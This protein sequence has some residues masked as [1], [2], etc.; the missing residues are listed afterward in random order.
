M[1]VTLG[2]MLKIAKDMHDTVATLHSRRHQ[3]S[4]VTYTEGEPPIQHTTTV[5]EIT[6]E[7]KV[8]FMRI[9]KLRELI[10]K[11]NLE[12]E[13]DYKI[14]DKPISLAEALTLLGQLLSERR[15]MERLGAAMP[16]TRYSHGSERVD[17]T[18]LTYDPKEMQASYKA[19]GVHVRQLRTAIDRANINVEVE[20]P[21]SYL[22][23]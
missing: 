19:L 20:I 21:D 13:V 8:L 23:Y 6:E 9:R 12:T 18:E 3:V 17:Y 10:A 16:K 7:I 14:N 4:T 1:L 5:P 22:E 2:D 15:Q 11:C